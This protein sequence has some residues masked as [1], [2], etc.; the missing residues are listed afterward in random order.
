MKGGKGGR[1]RKPANGSATR[2]EGSGSRGKPPKRG[3][4][5]K[6]LATTA[7]KNR[8]PRAQQTCRT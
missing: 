7:P 1:P 4:G 5:G 6:P 2:Q 8:R 3:G